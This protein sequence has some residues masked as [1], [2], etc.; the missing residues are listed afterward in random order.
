MTDLLSLNQ[1]R[2]QLARA[3]TA[4]AERE[5]AE[6]IGKLVLADDVLRQWSSILANARSLLL[7][8]PAA[9]R[10]QYPGLPEVGNVVES[11][12]YDALRELSG[13]TPAGNNGQGAGVVASAAEAQAK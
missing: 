9:V 4:R 13:D 8:I 10:G 3:Q 11:I 6:A 5:H 2:A 12:V 7:A 1:E